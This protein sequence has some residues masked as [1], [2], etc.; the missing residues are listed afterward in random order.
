MRDSTSTGSPACIAFDQVACTCRESSGWC[1]SSHLSATSHSAAQERCRALIHVVDAPV[2][3][4]VKIWSGHEVGDV[5]VSLLALA[6]GLMERLSQS[7]VPSHPLQAHPPQ[8]EQHQGHGVRSRSPLP[9][10]TARLGVP[11]RSS[12]RRPRRRTRRAGRRSGDRGGFPAQAQ[13]PL[14]DLPEGLPL[15]ARRTRR[16]SSAWARRSSLDGRLFALTPGD[17]VPAAQLPFQGRLEDESILDGQQHEGRVASEGRQ[18]AEP[19]RSRSPSRARIWAA[20]SLRSTSTFTSLV[21]DERERHPPGSPRQGS[22]VG[23]GATHG[24]RNTPHAHARIRQPTPGIDRLPA[25]DT[26]PI[27]GRGRVTSVNYDDVQLGA[28]RRNVLRRRVIGV[29]TRCTCPC[30]SPVR[31]LS[32]WQSCSRCLHS[33]RP[34]RGT[35]CLHA[36]PTAENVTAYGGALMWSRRDAEG[37]PPSGSADR[38][39]SSP[40]L[41]SGRPD[42]PFDPDLGPGAKG[43]IVAVYRRCRKGLRRCDIQRLDLATGRERRWRGWRLEPGGQ[44]V[45]RLGVGGAVRVRARGADARGPGHGRSWAGAI[46]D[47][48]RGDRDR[49]TAPHDRVRHLPPRRER[50]RST[51]R[52]SMCIACLRAAAAR[53]VPGRPRRPGRGRR[54]P[55]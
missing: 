53:L 22:A 13:R 36:D 49:P 26:Q 10:T 1:R 43:R 23:L 31:W 2:G 29:L 14:G 12:C 32:C 18:V 17:L 37:P 33:P 4:I 40:M 54:A 50:C 6:R 52:A 8:L 55:R 7:R 21:I 15:T 48:A 11:G 38:E 42:L 47:R 9:V 16:V 24:L 25:V 35:R 45:R 27:I 46:P 34:P 3:P 30:T 5:A 28:S 20:S 41:R 39:R 44:R 51:T 19:R